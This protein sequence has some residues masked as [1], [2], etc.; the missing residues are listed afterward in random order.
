MNG[1][2]S[3]GLGGGG[4]GLPH[5]LVDKYSIDLKS[6]KAIY[7]LE[8]YYSASVTDFFTIMHELLQTLLSFD[9][10]DPVAN[11]PHQIGF[12]NL[13]KSKLLAYSVHVKKEFQKIYN[14]AKSMQ[15]FD[16]Q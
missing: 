12:V 15:T 4:L 14:E 10:S 16:H 5:E 3:T 2:V 6:T 11:L 13:I 7:E 9:S 8:N 1:T